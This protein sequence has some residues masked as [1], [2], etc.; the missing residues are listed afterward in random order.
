M[1]DR[2]AF[3]NVNVIDGL[4]AVTPDAT[5]LI[6]GSSIESV[7]SAHTADTLPAGT[8]IID[9]SGG[10]LMPGLINCHDHLC[11]KWLRSTPAPDYQAARLRRRHSNPGAHA[12]E[13]AGNATW[14]LRQGVTTVRELGG[15]GME[16]GQE[17]F[18]NVDIR[19]AIASG[20]IAGPRVLASRLMVAMTGGHGT[21]W[22]GVRE[23]DGPDEVRK[24]VRE[25]LK[26]GAD[27]IKIMSTAGLANY[28]HESPDTDEYTLEE[29]SAGADEAH[30]FNRL[31]TTHA[32]SDSAVKRAIEAGIDTIEHAFLATPGGIRAM[33]D[34]GVSFV[35]TARVAWRMARNSPPALA[36]LLERA[37]HRD[38]VLEAVDRGVPVGVG[39]DSRFTVLE[40]M[41]TLVEY[42]VPVE[43][44]LKGATGTAAAI[45]GL[46]DSGSVAPGKRADLLLLKT[47]PLE[48]LR[49]AFEG[50]ELVVK[51]GEVVVASGHS[52]AALRPLPPP[53]PLN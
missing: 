4:G 16:I 26:G 22:Y 34:G 47:N 25:Q 8:R 53:D 12:L 44:V 43:T 6:A 23:A 52:G 45:C 29:L 40:E 15:P 1:T 48:G 9:G 33:Q 3:N 28:P 24:A 49:S 5:V 46:D 41:E 39:T 13:A 38:R 11:N 35:P 42:G 19:N 51:A 31:I 36:G 2:L 27:C 21:P 37:S 10:W 18:T 14:E 50:L 20:Q 30:R 7:S 32:M 17:M